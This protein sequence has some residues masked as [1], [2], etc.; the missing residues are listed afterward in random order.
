MSV[1]GLQHDS[2]FTVK[3]HC[4]T[5]PT[6]DPN[7]N[8]NPHTQ[9]TYDPNPNPNPHTQPTYVADT[10]LIFAATKSP[11]IFQKVSHSVVCMMK[12]RGYTVLAYL[13]DYLISTNDELCLKANTTLSNRPPSLGVIVNFDNLVTPCKIL[14]FLGVEI[15]A[16]CRTF[17]SQ[18]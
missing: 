13:D 8:P 2:G 15:Y 7:P 12:R 10:T 3:C 5:Q 18:Y 17:I 11:D 9:P 1:V 4:H 16:E 6:Y 14:I